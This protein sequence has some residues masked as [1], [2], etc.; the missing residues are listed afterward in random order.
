MSDSYI[1]VFVR[2]FI[3]RNEVLTRGVCRDLVWFLGV[4]CSNK[5]AL[6]GH[7]DPGYL[8]IA[9]HIGFLP[10]RQAS[11]DYDSFPGL[12]LP[13]YVCFRDI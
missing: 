13:H 9:K 6:P 8:Y 7:H 3:I 10:K 11:P 2:L 5:F 4:S 1:H 12:D